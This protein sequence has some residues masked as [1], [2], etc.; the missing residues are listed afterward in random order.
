MQELLKRDSPLSKTVP[1]FSSDEFGLIFS[2]EFMVDSN[3]FN[4]FIIE[5]ID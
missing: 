1:N 4:Q 3:K 5:S 2:S